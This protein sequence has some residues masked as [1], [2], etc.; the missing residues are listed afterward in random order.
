MALFIK[1]LYDPLFKIIAIKEYWWWQV[2]LAIIIIVLF[3]YFVFRHL[4]HRWKHS[5]GSALKVAEF[6][7][8]SILK[9]S[10]SK[11]LNNLELT[12][13]ALID[14]PNTSFVMPLSG[15]LIRLESVPDPVFSSKVMGDGFAIRPH[16]NLLISPV[17][18]VIT[19]LFK[20]KHACMITTSDGVE[21]LIHIGM[22]TVNLSG[23]GFKILLNPGAVVT[24]GTPIIEFDLYK[25]AKN[26]PSMI[27]PVIF[28]NLFD[29]NKKLIVNGYNM[30]Y[31]AGSLIPVLVE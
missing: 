18:G 2:L 7:T 1:N 9:N 15:E 27:T 24:K 14:A 31:I 30:Q 23:E 22:D 19:M 21:I 13:I 20:T 29:L 6:E 8:S 26:V 4:I 28:T 10:L 17:D 5:K 25:I 11:K 12:P 3:Y 16:S